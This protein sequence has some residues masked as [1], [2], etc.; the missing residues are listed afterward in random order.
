MPHNFYL[1]SSLV[2]SREVDSTSRPQ[3]ASAC[4]YAL[5]DSIL[6]LNLAFF[7]NA[8]IL[9]VSAAVFYHKQGPVTEF[10][11]AHDLLKLLLKSEWAGFLFGLGLVA[12]GQSSTITGTMAGQIVMEGY[13]SLPHSNLNLNPTVSQH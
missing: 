5:I 2:Q 7:V 11:Q 13:S 1:H 3:V 4:R 10:Q 9:I 6:S 12:A 8:S